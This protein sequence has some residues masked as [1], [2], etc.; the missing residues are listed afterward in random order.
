MSN[1]R[2]RIVLLCEDS[3]QESFVR[4]FLQGTGWNNREIRVE[5]SPNAKGAAEQWV[6]ERFP[7]ELLAYRNR[8]SRAA[9]A[10]VAV[11]DA[12]IRSVLQRSDELCA[13][14][15]EEGVSFRSEGESVAIV[16]PK[17]NIETWIRYL[18]EIPGTGVDEEIKYP[19]L[20]RERECKPAVDRLLELCKTTGLPA[21]APPSLTA[22][23]S[24][25]KSRIGR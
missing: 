16:I 12:D 1:R 22:A 2:V 6:R 5:K 4:R 10:L 20:Q 18:E 23:C 7:K 8:S 14:C 15:R 17:R 3:Q 25:Y 19:K 24:E 9:S 13:A 21:N 11:I